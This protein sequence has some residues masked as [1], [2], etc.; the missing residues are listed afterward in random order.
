[1]M[2]A[3]N[4]A[5]EAKKDNIKVDTQRLSDQFHIPVV[6]VSGRTGEGIEELKKVIESQVQNTKTD[7]AAKQ[8]YDFSGEELESIKKIRDHFKLKNDFQALQWLHHGQWLPFLSEDQRKWLIE[9]K[10][11]TSFDSLRLQVRETMQR[12]DKFSPTVQSSLRRP[13]EECDTLTDQIDNV[14]THRF[15]GQM[16]FFGLLFLI[17]QA[18]FSWAGYPMDWID[19]GFG[20]LDGAVKSVLPFNC[21]ATPPAKVVTSTLRDCPLCTI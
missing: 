3:L 4:M 2:L 5:D 7:K 18:I 6:M 16:I 20:A 12:F 15:L 17:F 8:L 19:A 1:M 13:D 14:V 9:L 21:A 11:S 10:D